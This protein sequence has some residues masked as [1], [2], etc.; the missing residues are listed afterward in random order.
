MQSELRHVPQMGFVRA[1]S[2]PMRRQICGRI[3]LGQAQ[4][5]N[6]PDRIRQQ[7]RPSLGVS[8]RLVA[9]ILTK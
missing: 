4:D 7:K 2:Y 6:Q 5:T 1:L 8:R 3:V 9:P